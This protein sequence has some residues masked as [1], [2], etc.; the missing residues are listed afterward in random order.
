[1]RSNKCNLLELF[2]FYFITN[3]FKCSAAGLI[4]TYPTA[5][6]P[7]YECKKSDLFKMYKIGKLWLCNLRAF[8][9]ILFGWQNTSIMNVNSK[10]EINY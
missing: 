4:L 2:T 5:G 10:H 9:I 1:M 7:G 3:K 8:R 6:Y